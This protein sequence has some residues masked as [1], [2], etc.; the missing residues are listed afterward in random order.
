MGHLHHV[1]EGSEAA[2]S[3]D[4]GK[5]KRKSLLVIQ[6]GEGEE[7]STT[8]LLPRIDPET[9]AIFQKEEDALKEKG[10]RWPPASS[11]V[12]RGKREIPPG[13]SC[14]SHRKEREKSVVSAQPLDREIASFSMSTPPGGGRGHFSTTQGS[15][16]S[17][18]D[19]RIGPF[20]FRRGRRPS[21]IRGAE[22][23]GRT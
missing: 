20:F 8:P 23:G 19:Q 21:K 16:L 7:G 15:F 12:I 22:R 11:I 17:Y 14:L 1:V 2:R 3:V 5:K 18:R 13:S 9:A 6:A 10:G 4:R